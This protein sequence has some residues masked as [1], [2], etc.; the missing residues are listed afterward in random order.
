ME[1]YTFY[2]EEKDPDRVGRTLGVVAKKGHYSCTLP[3]L[4]RE[5]L[6]NLKFTIENYLNENK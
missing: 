4:N 1:N 5:E 6:T 2:I 3:N